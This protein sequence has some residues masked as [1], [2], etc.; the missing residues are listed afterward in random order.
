MGKSK[1]NALIINLNKKAFWV[2]LIISIVF[3]VVSFLTPPP[4]QIHASVLTAVGELAGFACLG[5]V[6]EAVSKG[7]DITV[8]KGDAKVT[9]DSK[10][11]K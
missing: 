1:W 8:E 6:V 11:G 3:L 5:T 7:A 2:C 4:F 10:D 9:I